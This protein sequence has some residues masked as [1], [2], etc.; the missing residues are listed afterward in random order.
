[1]AARLCLPPLPSQPW[2]DSMQ[3]RAC[4]G[5][6]PRDHQAAEPPPRRHDAAE[7]RR[8]HRRVQHGQQPHIQVAVCGGV[9]L[10]DV[11]EVLQAPQA[12]AQ[13]VERRKGG[14]A[15]LDQPGEPQGGR[16][17]HGGWERRE[18]SVRSQT[19]FGR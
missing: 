11:E 10:E 6:G 4:L 8:H 19:A 5:V 13:R 7:Q 2:L 9:E 18:A 15:Q 16:G 17:A 3:R 12:A 14:G 1:M